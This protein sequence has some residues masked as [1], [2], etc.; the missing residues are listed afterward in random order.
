MTKPFAA[1]VLPMLFCMVAACDRGEPARQPAQPEPAAVTGQH[2][3]VAPKPDANRSIMRPSVVPDSEP[4]PEPPK[5]LHVVVSFAYSTTSLDAAARSQ[6]DA[7][8]KA[9]EVAAGGPITLRGSTDSRGGDER[10]RI[11]SAR[12]AGMVAD[13][14]AGHG[15]AR[16]RMT[17]VALGEDRPIAPNANLD[18][19]DDAQGR[20][21]N[22]RV[23]IV[24]EPV[25]PPPGAPP[26]DDRPS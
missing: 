16:D 1:Q 7:L 22:R 20:G 21:R 11:V 4:A 9:P 12:R 26:A 3:Q 8:S 18:G 6:L 15:V 24:V 13:Y 17:I 23:D 5:P 14:L 19:S 10:N 25:S 2:R